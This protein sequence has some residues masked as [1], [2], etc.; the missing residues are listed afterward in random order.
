MSMIVIHKKEIEGIPTLEVIPKGKENEPLPCVFYFHGFTSAKE[1]NL[2]FAYMLAE[3][4]Y[5]VLL[6]DSMYHGE[7]AE[8]IS[9]K[10]FQLSFWNIV[11]KNIEEGDVLHS[12]IVKSNLLTGGRIGIAGTSMGGITVSSMLVKY[13]WVQSIGIFMGT[14][15][16]TD[17]AELLLQQIKHAGIEFPKEEITSIMRTI[18]STDLSKHVDQ[19]GGKSIFMWHGEKDAVIPFT[20][21]EEFY[22]LV[23]KQQDRPIKIDFMKDK[24]AGHKVSREAF[25][26]GADWLEQTV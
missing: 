14:A 26:T 4:G 22:T 1:H 7:R 12:Y 3:R 2:P 16:T 24:N 17:Y 5:R 19:I 9:E 13:D 23:K 25:L 8:D 11:Q 21:A 10:E 20:Y 18:E 15:K 6:P